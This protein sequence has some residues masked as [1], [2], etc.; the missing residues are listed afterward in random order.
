M[1]L[2]NDDIRRNWSYKH[3]AMPSTDMAGLQVTTY[4]KARDTE[5]RLAQIESDVRTIREYVININ[6]LVLE[7]LSRP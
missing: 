4:Q 1:A 6:W 3:A 2:S 7:L 5:A